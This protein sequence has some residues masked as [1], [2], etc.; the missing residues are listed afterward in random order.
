MLWEKTGKNGKVYH[1]ILK[2]VEQNVIL[3]TFRRSFCWWSNDFQAVNRKKNFE[4][5]DKEWKKVIE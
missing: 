5:K 2:L 1:N 3:N 4:W